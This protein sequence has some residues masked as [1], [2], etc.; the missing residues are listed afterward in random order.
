ML[1][2]IDPGSVLEAKLSQ[3]STSAAFQ[4]Q[5]VEGANQNETIELYDCMTV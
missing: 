5:E 1:R 3:I 2:D 4:H